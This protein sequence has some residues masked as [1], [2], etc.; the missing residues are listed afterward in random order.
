[1]ALCMHVGVCG[2]GLVHERVCDFVCVFVC[3]I[4]SCMSESVCVVFI[5]YIAVRQKTSTL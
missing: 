3:V 4:L 5:S 1:M 2:C